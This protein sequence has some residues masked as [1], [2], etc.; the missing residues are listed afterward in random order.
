MPQMVSAYFLDVALVTQLSDLLE[1]NCLEETIL[2]GKDLFMPALINK[3]GKE[4][5]NKLIIQLEKISA[6]NV[7]I[8]RN[9]YNDDQGEL[10]R[11]VMSY[12]NTLMHYE[13]DSKIEKI[14]SL[15]EG[16]KLLNELLKYGDTR[17]KRRVKE[18]TYKYFDEDFGEYFNKAK[19]S[20]EDR[21]G[22]TGII[23]DENEWKEK[24]PYKLFVEG[25]SEN[26]RLD[27]QE[28]SKEFSKKYKKQGIFSK[29]LKPRKNN[30]DVKSLPESK[31]ENNSYNTDMLKKYNIDYDIA[32]NGKAD[33][34]IDL[35]IKE[36]ENN[37]TK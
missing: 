25:I 31:Y 16:K 29:F 36:N 10:E 35:Q 13:F 19:S 11:S 27:I 33:M 17:V 15:E 12:Q 32:Y 3:F 1:E 8:K 20:I 9:G 30:V 18:D 6:L 28:M 5:T 7:K 21:F 14:N 23:Y 22:K 4:K 24:Y 26:E 34:E 2:T 37:I